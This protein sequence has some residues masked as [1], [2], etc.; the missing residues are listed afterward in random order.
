MRR[1][2]VS[3]RVRRDALVDASLA[4]RILDRVPHDF[5]RDRRVG[6][7]ALARARK[8]IRLRAHPPVVLAQSREQGRAER[9]LAIVAALPPF[10]A[11]HHPLAVDVADLEVAQL[12]SAQ[13]RAI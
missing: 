2:G 11:Q 10:D 12:R 4:H 1:V 13:T 6:A 9:N 3:E 8:E 7:P 5:R